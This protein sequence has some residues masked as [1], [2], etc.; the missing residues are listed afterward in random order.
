VGVVVHNPVAHC[1]AYAV[2]AG[3][4]AA[5]NIDRPEERRR[6]DIAAGLPHTAA[7]AG[8]RRVEGLEHRKVGAAAAAVRSPEGAADSMGPRQA[9]PRIVGEGEAVGSSLLVAVGALLS[10]WLVV[11]SLSA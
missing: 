11:P 9:V 1:I 2:A 5:D 3:A 7:E 10:L 6:G 4:G 8:R